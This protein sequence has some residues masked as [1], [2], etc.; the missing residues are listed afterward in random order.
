MDAR[1]IERY[2]QRL[3][4]LFQQWSPWLLRIGIAVVFIWFG[5]LK[6][7]GWSPA[8][9]LVTK[10][11]YW[12]NPTWFVSILGWWEVIIGVL[13]LFPSLTRAAI[14]LLAPQM[15]G[16]FLPLL[17]LPEIVYQHGN[18]LLLTLEGQYIVKNLVIIASAITL[19]AQLHALHLEK[20][21][22][23]KK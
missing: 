2:D 10:T 11:V 1:S 12:F 22:K 21:K 19:G 18:P 16:T 14:A 17:L 8:T 5:G 23:R 15:A 3:R 20:Q 9:D 7:I 4:T 13:F 6:V